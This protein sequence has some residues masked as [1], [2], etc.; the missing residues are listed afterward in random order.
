MMII[1]GQKLCGCVDHVPGKCYVKTRFLHFYYVPVFP[2]SSWAIV[3]GTEKN[4]AF[5]GQQIPLS[6]KSVM[7]GWLHTGLVIFGTFS[8]CTGAFM[9]TNQHQNPNNEFDGVFS[10]VV[11][12]VCLMIWMLFSIWPFLASEERAKQLTSQLQIP[13]ET[14][15]ESFYRD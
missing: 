4:S 12:G 3:Q 13:Y 2:L 10:A 15:A 11:G 7:L 14:S 6:F 9:L 1:V 5:R 8:L